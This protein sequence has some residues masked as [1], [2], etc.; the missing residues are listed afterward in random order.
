MSEIRVNS[1]VS[2]DGL[3]SVDLPTGTSGIGSDIKFAPSII[4]YSPEE[5]LVV[6]L[7]HKMLY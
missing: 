2:A 7:T 6:L 4:D 1:I 3:G 5:G